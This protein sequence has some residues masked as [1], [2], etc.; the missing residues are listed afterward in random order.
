MSKKDLIIS[1]PNSHLRQKSKRVAVISDEVRQVIE[2]MKQATLD[3]E[4]SRPHEVGVALAA[5]QIDQPYR[6]V[7]VRNDF[8]NKKDKGFNVLINPEVIKLEGEVEE[9][10][11]GCLSV[12][13]IYGKVPRYTKIR[14]RALNELGQPVRVRAEGFLARILQ[15]EIDH[16]VGKMFVDYIKDQPDAF[17]KLTADGKLVSMPNATLQETGIFRD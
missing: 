2:E 13:D 9:D 17:F 7:I 16:T 8:E 12:A 1:L 11:E 4:A 10:Y 6:I 15:H 3:W 5:I 14:L